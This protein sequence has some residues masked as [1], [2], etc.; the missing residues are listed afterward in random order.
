MSGIPE[1][2]RVWDWY[3]EQ[4][5]RYRALAGR[6]ERA[7]V[8][9]L[10]AAVGLEGRLPDVPGKRAVGRVARL[11]EHQLF[12]DLPPEKVFPPEAF[13]LTGPLDTVFFVA[14]VD[15]PGAR[16]LAEPDE[17]ADRM[18]FCCNTS[19]CRSW[20]TIICGGSPSPAA[21]HADR[22]RR[23]HPARA[24]ALGAGEQAAI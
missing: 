10:K 22:K 20:N 19:G 23:S 13:A 1:P 14:S 12:V 6:A 16:P 9:G 17:A 24:I 18:V 5:P 11:L 15:A 21:E 7:R 2:I 8:G 4:M 3:L